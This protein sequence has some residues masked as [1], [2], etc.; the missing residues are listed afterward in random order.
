MRQRQFPL[1]LPALLLDLEKE[2]S[3]FCGEVGLQPFFPVVSPA[4][5]YGIEKDEYAHELAQATVWIG[6]LQWF[7]ENGMASRPS[8]S[9]SRWTISN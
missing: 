4:Q 7:H 9:S 1:H 6:Y 5:L 2:V 8:R 3:N